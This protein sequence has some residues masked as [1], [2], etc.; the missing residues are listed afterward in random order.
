MCA[1][2]ERPPCCAEMHGRDKATA[3]KSVERRNFGQYVE[4]SLADGM[5]IEY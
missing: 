2:A 4:L 1:D 5:A 3:V